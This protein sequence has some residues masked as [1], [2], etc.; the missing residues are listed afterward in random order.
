[1]A[2]VAAAKII[3]ATPIPAAAAAAGEIIVTATRRGTWK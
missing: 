1:V 3:G 2:H